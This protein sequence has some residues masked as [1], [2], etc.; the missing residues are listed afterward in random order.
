MNSTIKVV[1]NVAEE[2]NQSNEKNDSTKE[3]ILHINTKIEES[4]KEKC[5]SRVM[6]GQYIRSLESQL[7]SEE[8]T[9]LWLSR[10]D[11]KGE[12]ENS[13]IRSGITN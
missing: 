2:L 4:L 9:F 7:I 11:L 1:G 8:D 13:S 5:E 3:G 10:G 12:T 6:H